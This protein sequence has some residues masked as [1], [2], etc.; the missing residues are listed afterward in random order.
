MRDHI[1]HIKEQ[2]HTVNFLKYENH[3]LIADLEPIGQ[4]DI[5]NKKI[6]PIISV[7]LR[8]GSGTE[9]TKEILE[10]VN[11]LLED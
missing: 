7:P 3:K 4:F 5:T 9:K 10:I 2:T 1:G 11:V 8:F 6:R